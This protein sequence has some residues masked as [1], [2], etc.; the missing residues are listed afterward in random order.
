[1]CNGKE[2]PVIEVREQENLSKM[3]RA[4]KV[5]Q[6]ILKQ[7]DRRVV[8]KLKCGIKRQRWRCLEHVQRDSEWGTG[9]EN[10]I[11]TPSASLQA[12]TVWHLFKIN[13][14]NYHS[15]TVPSLGFY[16]FIFFLQCLYIRAPRFISAAQPQWIINGSREW[17]DDEWRSRL[18]FATRDW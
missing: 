15:A 16:N 9:R 8:V 3:R 12:A 1:M 7:K 17:K 5:K 18:L 14:R 2:N 10:E 4:R 13:L 6:E 11:S